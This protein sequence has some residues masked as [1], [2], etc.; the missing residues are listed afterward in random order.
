MLFRSLGLLGTLLK[1]YQQLEQPQLA[2]AVAHD[3]LTR[4]PEYPVKSQGTYTLQ[5]N[6]IIPDSLAVLEKAEKS[7][8]E[9]LIASLDAELQVHPQAARPRELLKTY[10]ALIGQAEV[11]AVRRDEV[12]KAQGLTAPQLLD[13]ARQLSDEGQ[14]AT[15]CELSVLAYRR[16][17]KLLQ[18]RFD[19]ARKLFAAAEDRKST[20]LNSSH[21]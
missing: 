20:R 5:S 18:S 2:A 21:T 19:D 7:F 14:R 11:G 12:T 1:M 10:R 16:D 3:I 9:P 17:P 4:V 8:I 15:A 6:T 13:R